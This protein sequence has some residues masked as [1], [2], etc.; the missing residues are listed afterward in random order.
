MNDFNLG[1]G[2]GMIQGRSL[3]PRSTENDLSEAVAQ[4]A[5]P[6]LQYGADGC[7]S[8]GSSPGTKR[9]SEIY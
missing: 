4:L 9:K 8:G 3:K 1:K 6:S 2:R 7:C 5:A